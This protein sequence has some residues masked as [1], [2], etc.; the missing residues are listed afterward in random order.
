MGKETGTDKSRDMAMGPESRGR[1]AAMS[2]HPSK[3]VEEPKAWEEL[4]SRFG[5]GWA[6]S[7]RAPGS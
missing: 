6:H 7:R 3:C 1:P 2:Q 4:W 5:N